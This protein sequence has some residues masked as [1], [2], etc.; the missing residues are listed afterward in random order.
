[1][2]EEQSLHYKE[3]ELC[4]TLHWL[5]KHWGMWELTVKKLQKSLNLLPDY[6]EYAC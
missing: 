6:L 3:N 2:K 1:M 4:K 5:L